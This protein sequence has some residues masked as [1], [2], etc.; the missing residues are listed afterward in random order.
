MPAPSARTAPSLA[1]R[2]RFALLALAVCASLTGAPSVAEA[3]HPCLPIPRV[4]D[5][6]PAWI[7]SFTGVTDSSTAMS[8]AGNLTFATGTG[9]SP[10]ATHR[11]MLVTAY[12]TD[13]GQPAWTAH[14][15]GPASL[16]DM[17]VSS[18]G[19]TV[20]ITGVEDAPEVPPGGVNETARGNQATV[21]YDTSTG[22]RRW[23]VSG[24]AGGG[25]GVTYSADG[26]HVYSA[27]SIRVGDAP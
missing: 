14:H 13:T 12:R 7:Q 11:D 20:A 27:G 21:V 3:S 6:C 22:E 1:R 19:S 4:N 18:E 8:P 26:K 17:P 15:N 2:S 25:F 24:P 10:G 5:K 16:Q 23:A 9:P